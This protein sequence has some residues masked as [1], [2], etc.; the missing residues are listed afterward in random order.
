M[1]CAVGLLRPVWPAGRLGLG[2]RHAGGLVR[3]PVGPAV[4]VDLRQGEACHRAVEL[5][6]VWP[7]V[8]WISGGMMRAVGVLRPVWPAAR[9]D[10]RRDEARRRRCSC[11]GGPAV[12]LDLR[13]GEA[14]HRVVERSSGRA[15]AGVACGCGWISGRV[16]CAS[17]GCA[18]RC[19]QRVRLDLGQDE[20]CRRAARAGVACWAVGF[21][22]GCGVPSGW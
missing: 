16:R 6:P 17:G 2:M 4:R 19:G 1:R 20:A 3:V 15:G 21:P 13:Q 14:C 11:L 5:V 12:R 22:S 18:C 8:G 10:L 9:W 7:A